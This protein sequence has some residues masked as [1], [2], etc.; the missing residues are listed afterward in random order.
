M[1]HTTALAVRS[2]ARVTRRLYRGSR[3]VPGPAPHRC[4]HR[5]DQS[6]LRTC[7]RQRHHR[8]DMP[9]Q[10]GIGTG[11]PRQGRDQ[12]HPDQDRQG[13]NRQDSTAD[14]FRDL[15]GVAGQDP[16]PRSER[17]DDPRARRRG[18]AGPVP[19]RSPGR[20]WT[21]R[22]ARCRSSP[23]RRPRSSTAAHHATEATDTR[24]SPAVQSC[25]Q[26]RSS[27]PRASRGRVA[28]TVETAT[29]AAPTA[30][31]IDGDVARP[32]DRTAATGR[33]PAARSRAS[34]AQRPSNGARRRTIAHTLA[35][36]ST[37]TVNQGRS[38]VL[39]TRPAA[40][41]PGITSAHAGR[42]ERPAS[43]RTTTKP[44][45]A[46]AAATGTPS[47][48]VSARK[49][50][51]HQSGW[52]APGTAGERRVDSSSRATTTRTPAAPTA[53][54]GGTSACTHVSSS[55]RLRMK[56][57]G[58]AATSV[59]SDRA[60]RGR[61][62]AQAAV[63]TRAARVAAIWALPGIATASPCGIGRPRPRHAMATVNHTIGATTYR[64]PLSGCRWAQAAYAAAIAAHARVRVTARAVPV[65]S[66]GAAT[67]S[68]NEVVSITG[69]SRPPTTSRAR[70]TTTA[71]RRR[72]RAA[73]ANGTA[74]ITTS[75]TGRNSRWTS[76][77]ANA[78]RPKAPTKNSSTPRYA[79]AVDG[80]VG[81]DRLTGASPPLDYRPRGPFRLLGTL[82]GV[83]DRGLG[84]HGCDPGARS[85]DGRSPHGSRPVGSGRHHLSRMA[86][87]GDR[88]RRRTS[89]RLRTQVAHDPANA[90]GLIVAEG[91]PSAQFREQDPFGEGEVHQVVRGESR[92]I[93]EGIDGEQLVAADP[94]SP[95]R[96]GPPTLFPAFAWIGVPALGPPLAGHFGEKHPGRT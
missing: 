2:S 15:A 53:R 90:V 93:D 30:R 78:T 36:A 84:E 1:S 29:S 96:P 43:S 22:P 13:S 34:A 72:S 51:H 33:I 35:A 32:R 59:G 58:T 50:S 67:P 63:A 79:R 75:A 4:G 24:H 28:G 92:P 95:C 77:K 42:R 17:H 25:V 37:P 87:P 18:S 23:P 55:M 54:T 52:I 86:L 69:T 91:S 38:A 71:P 46:T 60:A 6:P 12:V 64:N 47:P 88:W 81:G 89:D 85:A 3:P 10:A 66:G 45:A 48:G 57:P 41:T 94:G 14:R 49:A 21:P 19:P 40:S 8:Q 26:N 20:A 62:R 39:G 61:S 70:P 16:R 44:T 68:R 7:E 65:R 80:E 27:G 11:I 31:A 9:S 83:S 82:G 76:P 56:S 73:A 74:A 5:D